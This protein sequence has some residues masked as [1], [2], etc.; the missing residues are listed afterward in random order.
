MPDEKTPAHDEPTKAKARPEAAA[1][2]AAAAALAPAQNASA[3][4]TEKAA[5]TR[6]AL[7]TPDEWAAVTGRTRVPKVIVGVN[8]VPQKDREFSGEHT[9]AARLHRWGR[10]DAI[11]REIT[12]DAY[13]AAIRATKRAP[14]GKRSPEPHPDAL[15]ESIHPAPA[16]EAKG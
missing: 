6:K 12:R 9:A 11:P 10:H 16:A 13:E 1:A 2:P 5:E 4:P 15:F 14:E 8:G 3:E 7:R